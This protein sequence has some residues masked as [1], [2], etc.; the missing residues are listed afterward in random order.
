MPGFGIAR[1]RKIGAVAVAL[2][3]GGAA[4]TVATGA[5]GVAAAAVK[6][7]DA[8]GV[9]DAK[10]VRSVLGATS[11]SAGAAKPLPTTTGS[12]TECSWTVDG[13][14]GALG[15]QLARVPKGKAKRSYD[16]T[17][18]SPAETPAQVGGIGKAAKYGTV[19]GLIVLVDSSSVLRV[20]LANNG[21]PRDRQEQAVLLARDAVPRVT[22]AKKPATTRSAGTSTGGAGSASSANGTVTLTGPYDGKW[23]QYHEDATGR[24]YSIDCTYVMTAQGRR[25]FVGGSSIAD[26]ETGALYL[27]LG[28]GTGMPPDVGDPGFADDPDVIEPGDTIT[29]KGTPRA[30]PLEQAACG[31]SE[32]PVLAGNAGVSKG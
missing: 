25:Q 5:T 32:P 4:G 12:A 13:A 27:W 20:A 16:A 17:A 10:E 2:A 14:P 31:T 8:C 23:V 9:L 21:S 26:T 6:P 3:L 22:G 1:G 24:D 7:A 30:D 19:L 28:T 15:L 18:A 11:V 29:V